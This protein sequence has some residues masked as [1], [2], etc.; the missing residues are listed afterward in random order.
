MKHSL[1]LVGISLGAAFVF[2]G[3]TYDPNWNVLSVENLP[4]Q[5]QATYCET[6]QDSPKCVMPIYL[7]LAEFRAPVSFASDKTIALDKPGKVYAYQ[8]YLFVTYKQS[9]TDGGVVVWDISDPANPTQSGY[10]AIHGA[11]DVA[12]RDD[13]LYANSFTDLLTIDL[14]NLD[15]PAL[16]ANDVFIQ[17]AVSQF[18]HA[19]L[20]LPDG[21]HFLYTEMNASKGLIV[22][23]TTQD[24]NTYDLT[25]NPNALAVTPTFMP[26]TAPIEMPTTVFTF[27]PSPTA[28]QSATIT[29]EPSL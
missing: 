18:D 16:R 5:R 21:Y 19:A 7:P 15:Q 25:E 29:T 10:F 6:L 3:C 28:T 1:S 23:F 9:Y 13:Y 8:H 11:S 27:T 26:T 20:L 22:G 24:G 2:S 14:A 4:P 12:I 17:E